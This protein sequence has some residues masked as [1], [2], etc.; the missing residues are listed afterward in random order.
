MIKAQLIDPEKKK[1]DPEEALRTAITT[2]ILQRLQLIESDMKF[3]KLPQ[4]NYKRNPLLDKPPIV[5]IPV[6]VSRRRRTNAEEIEATI[7][8]LADD[9]A[10]MVAAIGQAEK[11]AT[12][13]YA[14]ANALARKK[15]WSDFN[16]V[17]KRWIWAIRRVIRMRHVQDIRRMLR[18]TQEAKIAALALAGAIP[19][20]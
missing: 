11:V 2:F 8:S 18:E 19:H 5:L 1:A 9:R 16:P 7:S 17:R 12:H 10:A 15:W 20:A 4:D 3:V 13:V 6:V 14:S